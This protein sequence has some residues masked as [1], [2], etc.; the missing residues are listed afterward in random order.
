MRMD[1]TLSGARLAAHIDTIS[2]PLLP[3]LA[4]TNPD[5]YSNLFTALS[6][7]A[8]SA[9]GANM[10]LRGVKFQFFKPPMHVYIAL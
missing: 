9:S 5:I 7:F 3:Q 8:V 6:L 1:G 4:P 10:H 2:G